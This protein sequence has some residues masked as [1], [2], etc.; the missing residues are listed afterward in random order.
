MRSSFCNNCGLSGHLFQSCK[1]PITS[2]GIIAFRRASN[3][4][5]Q[6]LLICRKDSL[7]YVDFI[8]GKY[9]INDKRYLRNIFSEMTVDEKLNLKTKSFDEMWNGLWGKEIG[10]QYRGEEK[11]SR[12]KYERLKNGVSIDGEVHSISTLISDTPIV[13]GEPEW[14]FPK[15]RRNYHEKDI[16]CALREFEE[17]TGYNKNDTTIMQN[18]QPIEEIF[19]GSN[20]KSYRHKYFVANM[21]NTAVPQN[22]YE[23]SEVSEMRWMNITE[24]LSHI[25]PYNIEKRKMIFDLNTALTTFCLYS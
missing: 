5:I 3:G 7:G 15:G 11:S 16:S 10:I 23:D 14:G 6:Y 8:R 18:I 17:E 21:S 2:I 24:V 22:R 20:Y 25:R 1:S 12:A 4:E 19:T 9:P 13:W